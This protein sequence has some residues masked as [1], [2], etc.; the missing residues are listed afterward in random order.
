MTVASD[1]SVTPGIRLGQ[2]R[3]TS[4]SGQ[5]LRRSQRA[6]L[7]DVVALGAGGSPCGSVGPDAMITIYGDS[8]SGNCLKVKF[9]AE[10]LGMSILI[11]EHDAEFMAAAEGLVAMV[12]V[13]WR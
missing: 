7:V 12:S 9:I 1:A 11:G 3:A 4:H 6:A 8:G 13:A 5:A 10:R 2:N